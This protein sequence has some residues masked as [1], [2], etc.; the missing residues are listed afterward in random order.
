MTMYKGRTNRFRFDRAKSMATTPERIDALLHQT[1]LVN[2]T[3][4]LSAGALEAKQNMEK[5]KQLKGETMPD[6]KTALSTALEN[7]KRQALNATLDAWEKDEKE[8]QLEKPVT[9]GKTSLFEVTNNVTRETFNF[10]RDNPR[11]TMADIK[12]ELGRKGFNTASVGSLLTQF[13]LQKHIERTEFGQYFTSKA[14]YSPLMS[15]AKWERLNGISVTTARRQRRKDKL[16]EAMVQVKQ[17]LVEKGLPVEL[18]KGSGIGALPVKHKKQ[19][20]TSILVSR[21]WTAQGVVDKLTVMQ[22]RQLYDLL[23]TIF[24]G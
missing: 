20:I 1:T 8:T 18:A 2:P 4:P 10:V 9:I 23:K 3:P 14:E 15:R 6:M 7:G 19:E 17:N 11:C 13:V 5:A 12:R 24:G 21:N 22:A 16:K